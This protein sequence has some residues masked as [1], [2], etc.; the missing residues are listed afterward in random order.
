[1]ISFQVSS[2]ISSCL[3]VL[4][5]LLPRDRTEKHKL[6]E[7]TFHS[8]S[9]RR[10]C[11][12][13]CC[14]YCC[15]QFYLWKFNSPAVKRL[16]FLTSSRVEWTV[17]PAH[18]PSPSSRS[19]LY[20]SYAGKPTTN[21]DVPSYYYKASVNIVCAFLKPLLL[22]ACVGVCVRGVCVVECVWAL[23]CVYTTTTTTTVGPVLQHI[24][25]LHLRNYNKLFLPSSSQW[26]ILL[27]SDRFFYFDDVIPWCLSFIWPT[28]LE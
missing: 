23:V 18:T 6:C 9:V 26:G 11:C 13:C 20:V 2:C 15:C 12:R 16:L 25:S 5:F 8:L 10:C 1:M 19:M 17:L 21:G 14:C 27:D 24:L 4:F 28:T 22:R 7:N 3:G